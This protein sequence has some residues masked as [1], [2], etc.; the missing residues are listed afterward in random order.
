MSDLRSTDD[1]MI[2]FENSAT[3]LFK[4]SWAAN[5]MDDILRIQNGVVPC[6]R[7]RFMGQRDR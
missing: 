5:L 3:L 7:L 6:F 2:R 4:V 1:G